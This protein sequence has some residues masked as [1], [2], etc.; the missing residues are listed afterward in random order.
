MYGTERCARAISD[1][2]RKSLRNDFLVGNCHRSVRAIISRSLARRHNILY[3]S[4]R[5]VHAT[6]H[7]SHGGS[8]VSSGLQH[9][10][11]RILTNERLLSRTGAECPNQGSVRIEASHVLHA[12]CGSII[13]LLTSQSRNFFLPWEQYF[14]PR[15]L[16]V[17]VA[18]VVLRV[19]R[20]CA[21]IP[22]DKCLG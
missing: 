15:R 2:G 14:R 4:V 13:R 7:R 22:V 11:A 6:G 16:S 8:T 17:R 10:P 20:A 1:V 5:G 9:G 12:P 21:P 19:P 18:R 3:A